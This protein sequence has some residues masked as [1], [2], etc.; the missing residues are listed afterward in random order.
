MTFK[1]KLVIGGLAKQIYQVMKRKNKT[2][3]MEKAVQFAKKMKGIK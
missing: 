1:E 3:T 2:V